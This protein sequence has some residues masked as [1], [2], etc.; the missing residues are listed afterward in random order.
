MQR[1]DALVC[2]IGLLICSPFM[3]AAIVIAEHSVVLVWVLIA[4][5]EVNFPEKASS[6][7]CT[8]MINDQ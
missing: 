6:G 1:A 7:C 8:S 3:L 4:I 2:S 5:A